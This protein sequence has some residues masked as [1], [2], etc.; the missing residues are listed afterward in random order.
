MAIDEDMADGT[1]Y[2]LDYVRAYA[3]NHPQARV[4]PEHPVKYGKTIGCTDAE[5][6]GTSDVIIDNYPHELIALDYK[7]G[8]GIPVSVKDNTQ[9]RLY[10]LGQR[11]LRGSYRRY[12]KV[13]VQPRLPKRKPVQEF[14]LTESELMDWTKKV[15][16]PV[17]P[18][19][20]SKTAPRVAGKHC[21]YCA[22]DGNCDAQYNLVMA[23]AK[24]DFK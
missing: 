22:A 15:V 13:V 21:R 20:L 3:A 6:F 1:G 2:A 16:I 5:A 9:L 11:Q 24:K 17:V 7:H 18:V 14:S 19:A 23:A 4:L 8:V 10:L 12:R